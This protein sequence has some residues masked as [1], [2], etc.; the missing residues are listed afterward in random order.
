MARRKTS[1]GADRIE[2][3]R[4]PV[5]DPDPSEARIRVEAAAVCATDVHLLRDRFGCTPPVTLGHEF[6]GRVDAL[7]GGV[8]GLAPGDRVVS[9]NN[10]RACGTCRICG[11]GLP[12]LCPSKRAMGIH[13]DGALAEYAVLS[14]NL[15]L[16]VPP[17][18]EPEGAALCDQASLSGGVKS[19]AVA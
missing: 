18:V 5:P 13:S 8:E 10:P 4:V 2:L 9:M 6:C 1:K 3:A 12:N 15:L 14:A 7:G 19:P 16:K 17:G 11:L